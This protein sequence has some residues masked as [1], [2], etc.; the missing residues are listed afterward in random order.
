MSA[1]GGAPGQVARWGGPLQGPDTVIGV[2]LGGRP[3]KNDT[4]LMRG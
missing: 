3:C 1:F 2:G 4:R